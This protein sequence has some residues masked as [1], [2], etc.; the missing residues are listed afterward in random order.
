MLLSAFN[1]S[2]EGE[3]VFED[4]DPNAWYYKYVISGYTL[5]IISGESET[6]FGVGNKI[7]REQMAAMSY[8]LLKSLKYELPADATS[9]FNDSDNISSYAV[10]PVGV[11]SQL[12]ILNGVGDNNFAPKDFATRAEAAV[13]IYKLYNSFKK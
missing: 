11:L 10:K 9:K 2:S 12:N 6:V 1:V 4:V 5:D 13:V 7:T 3:N 8:R